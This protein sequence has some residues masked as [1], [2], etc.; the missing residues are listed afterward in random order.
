MSFDRPV[1]SVREAR[2]SGNFVTGEQTGG[3]IGIFEGVIAPGHG[4]HWHTHTRETECFHVID[5][6]FRF[7]CGDEVCEG[8]PGTTVVAPPHLRH[9]WENIS[10]VPAHLLMW[11][12]PG[13]FER[14]F[15]EVDALSPPTAEA[16]FEIETRY[17][18]ISEILG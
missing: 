18:I 7:W 9:R 1:F 16:I 11:V 17:G 8:G 4:V 13:G 15:T 3:A 2:S 14:L 10:D 5:G 12:M 6:R